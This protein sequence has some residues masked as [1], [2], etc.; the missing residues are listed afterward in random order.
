VSSQLFVASVSSFPT[1][2]YFKI[3]N[4]V[5]SYTGKSSG[6]NNFTGV[7]RSQ[8]LTTAATH[9]VGTTVIGLNAATLNL[10]INS[11]AIVNDDVSATA[12]IDQSKLNLTDVTAFVDIATTSSNGIASFSSDN[13]AVTVGGEVTIKNGGIALAEIQNISAGRLLGN[14]T[15]SAAAPSEVTPGALVADG[16]NSEFASLDTGGNVLTKRT[17]SLK[18]SP[19]STFASI[20]GSAPAGSATALDLPV[21][22]VTGSGNG[23]RVN[24]PFG[25]GTYGGVNGDITVSFGGS[26][27][28][29]GDQLK[30]DGSLFTG[31]TSVSNDLT[32]IVATTGSNINTATILGI[33]KVSAI[34]EANSIVRTDSGKNLGG[35]GNRFNTI[36]G[37]VTDLAGGVKGD[38][39]YQNAAGDTVFLSPGT[40]GD[41]LK[42]N[43]TG[44]APSWAP[45]PS[46]AAA[47]LT[48]TTLAS[49]VVTS[50]LTS[51]GTLTSLTV[52]G[53]VKFTVDFG[54]TST[55]D[56]VAN[57]S[58]AQAA[59]YA[60][61]KN[62]TVV[63]TVP[64]ASGV[65]LP[66]TAP[67][68][69]K[70]IIRNNTVTPLYVWPPVGYDING[71]GEN[72]QF[73][74]GTE[75][76]LEFICAKNATGSPTPTGGLWFTMNSTYAA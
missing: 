3:G 22:S 31:G 12:A 51:V 58:G 69:S 11:G 7:Q 8:F 63:T 13:F 48:G 73:S 54:I 18:I 44:A 30:I 42:S 29:E 75:A 39:P 53:F 41:Y 33:H 27:Y 76:A 23:A 17:N 4:E 38:L 62:I 21:T 67:V 56:Y 71:N 35:L 34:A 43:G 64:A 28:A 45:V 15:G 16:I 9:T 47:D 36:Y 70:I 20:S 1:S 68:G 52:D 24:V 37:S 59:A 66:E 57:P 2:G 46:G 6:T 10:Q 72:V 32:F 50:S 26:G 5:F 40:S 14:L 65:R 49:G 74:L 19:S 60:I 55:G 61:T 25:G